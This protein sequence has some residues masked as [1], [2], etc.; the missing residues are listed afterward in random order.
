MVPPECPRGGEFCSSEALGGNFRRS[1]RF[2]FM[3]SH[4]MMCVKVADK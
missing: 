1:E 2:T 4:I 3:K